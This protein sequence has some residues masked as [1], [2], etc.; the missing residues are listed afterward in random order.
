M[1]AVLFGSISTIADTSE[2]QRDAFNRAFEAHGL[3]WRWD[4]AEYLGLLEHSGG[5]DRIDEYARTAGDAVDAQAVHHTKSELFQKSLA[6]SRLSAR[7]GVVETVRAAKDNG[8][9]VAFVTTTSRENISALMEAVR[10]DIVSSDFDFIADASSVD[11]PKPDG[12]AYSLALES[13]GQKPE[14]CVA[15][16]DNLGGVEAAKAAGL[17]CIAFPNE[18]T[19]DHDFAEA[20]RRVDR[21]GFSEV[22]DLAA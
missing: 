12:S 21:I 5:A 17:R 10:D 1:P 19:S 15:V 3:D 7:P 9:K 20:D 8:F 13:L 4:R 16:E 18:N 14:E 2:L 6:E 11:Q 22:Q